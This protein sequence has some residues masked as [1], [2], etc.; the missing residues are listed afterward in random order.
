MIRFFSKKNVSSF[1]LTSSGLFSE[2]TFYSAFIRDLCACKNDV[3]I[4]SPFIT[5]NRVASLLP[6]FKKMRSRG[7]K[8]I[9]NTKPI[10]EHPEPYVSQAQ[11]VI[12][13]L[14]SLGVIVLFTG[15]HHRKVAIIDRKLL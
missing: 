15:K 6:T 2:R 4:E 8:L 10:Y 11:Y 14:Q 3:V 12:D 5:T 13:T 9:I 7:I 1:D